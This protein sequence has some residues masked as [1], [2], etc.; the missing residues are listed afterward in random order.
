M[1][2]G[3]VAATQPSKQAKGEGFTFTLGL[4]DSSW[5]PL[6]GPSYTAF[7]G[8]DLMVIAGDLRAIAAGMDVLQGRRPS[9]ANQDEHNLKS[10]VPAG[11]IIV[12]AGVTANFRGAVG[13]A[14][15]DGNA[16]TQPAVAQKS[17]SSGLNLF[18]PITGKARLARAAYWEDGQSEHVS[19]TIGMTDTESAEQLK[20]LVVGM[21]SLVFLSQE[22]ARPFLAPLD[23][24]ATGTSVTLQW[25]YP[26]SKLVE[27][28]V[29]ESRK[30][31]D[32]SASTT[33]PAAR[34]I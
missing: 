32:S 26:T 29:Q 2:K 28:M 11:A 25:S 14:P 4:D 23:V 18:A 10:D 16:T 7:V 34:G 21:K 12:G 22:M 20:N 15:K 27:L 31:N 30:S 6:R 3:Q 8:D 13:E 33:R 24:Q 9:L 17:G 5:N 1:F 19:V